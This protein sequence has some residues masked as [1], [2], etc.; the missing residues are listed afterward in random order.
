MG[1]TKKVTAGSPKPG[2]QTRTTKRA[3]CGSPRL[4]VLL[5]AA[6]CLLNRVHAVK[7]KNGNELGWYRVVRTHYATT[8]LRDTNEVVKGTWI[9][10][11]KV[12]SFGSKTIGHIKDFSRKAGSP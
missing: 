1:T 5:V 9:K 2:D 8:K 12:E 10:V 6:L 3:R 11:R 7:D 4:P